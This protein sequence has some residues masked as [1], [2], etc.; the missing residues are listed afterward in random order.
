MRKIL[1][2][3]LMTII[4]VNV[5]GPV[6]ATHVCGGEIVEMYLGNGIPQLG[7]GMESE[8]GNCPSQGD[9]TLTKE[10]C[11]NDGLIRSQVEVLQS[12]DISFLDI[13]AVEFHDLWIFNVQSFLTNGVLFTCFVDLS[14]P[15]LVLE[16]LNIVFQVFR[17]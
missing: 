9:N 10:S 11:C 3:F 15:P 13:P 6:M 1:S 5:F 4:L 16:D 12:V 14:P 17:I 7:C 2:I 8:E